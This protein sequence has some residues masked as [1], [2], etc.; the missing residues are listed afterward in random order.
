M[1]EA[2]QCYKLAVPYFQTYYK[3]VEKV[4]NRASSV[5]K[6]HDPAR[7]MAK[8]QNGTKI[9]AKNAPA[10]KHSGSAALCILFLTF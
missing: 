2:C 3:M 6:G 7:N 5:A 10:E 8:E 9:F 4:L 1:Q